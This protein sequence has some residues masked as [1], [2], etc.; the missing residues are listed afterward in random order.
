MHPEFRV[1]NHSR[2]RE[3]A[4][5]N[6]SIMKRFNFCKINTYHFEKVVQNLNLSLNLTKSTPSCFADILEYVGKLSKNV[7]KHWEMLETVADKCD[8]MLAPHLGGAAY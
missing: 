6:G 4:Y 1:A 7:R 5:H 8:Q 3:I 2:L